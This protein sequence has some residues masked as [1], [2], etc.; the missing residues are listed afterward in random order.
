MTK[1]ARIY[2]GEKTVSFN[3]QHWE[4]WTTTCKTMKLKHSFISYRKI[5]SKWLKDLNLRHNTIKLLEDDIGKTFF[6]INRSNIFL[7]QSPRQKKKS[8]NK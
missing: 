8:K 4:S 7:D 6:D 5:N 2:N 3:K 1:E